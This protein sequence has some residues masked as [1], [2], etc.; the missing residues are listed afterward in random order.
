MPELQDSQLRV[1][2]SGL[3]LDTRAHGTSASP[4]PA[5]PTI[6]GARLLEVFYDREGRSA[7]ELRPLKGETV[8]EPYHR[9]LV[10]SNDMT[11][12]LEGFYEQRLWLRVLQRFQ[13]G[14]SYFREVAL[15]QASVALPVEYG[16]IR[17]DLSRFDRAPR[18]KIL[19]E[20]CPLGRV[21]QEGAI[22][23]TSWPRGFFQV[24]ADERLQAIL[25]LRRPTLLYGRRN[26]ILDGQ[27][28]LLADVV[29]ILQPVALAVGPSGKGPTKRSPIETN[30]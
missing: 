22:A 30:T 13:E 21:L 16:V 8:P 24:T 29:E 23:H 10:H 19:E 20:H 4:A 25:E 2:G 5:P 7:P 27:R 1:P 18:Q 6:G 15:I 12:T 11:P 26:L 14:D 3:T 28:R 9:L 17:I